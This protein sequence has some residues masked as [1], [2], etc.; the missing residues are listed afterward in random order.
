MSKKGSKLPILIGIAAVGAYR[1]YKGKGVFNKVR[2]KEQHD[3]VSDYLAG[4][5]PDAFYSDIAPTDEGWSCVVNNHG[6]RFV[7]YLTKSTDGIYVF[8]EKDCK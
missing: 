5:Y 7:L 4:H 8:W 6:N 3:A 1:L 2:F